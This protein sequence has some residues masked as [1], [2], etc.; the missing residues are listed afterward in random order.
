MGEDRRRSQSQSVNVISIFMAWFMVGYA[1]AINVLMRNMRTKLVIMNGA[2]IM[3]NSQLLVVTSHRT[4]VLTCIEQT[5]IDKVLRCAPCRRLC[6]GRSGGGGREMGNTAAIVAWECSHEAMVRYHRLMYTD[7]KV[8]RGNRLM[9]FAH[10]E[11]TAGPM[12]G[13]VSAVRNGVLRN[14]G[15]KFADAGTAEAGARALREQLAAAAAAL[16]RDGVPV[17]SRAPTAGAVDATRIVSG[18]ALGVVG[19][20][21]V[22][23]DPPSAA[24]A[25]GFGAAGGAPVPTFG[26]GAAVPVAVGVPVSQRTASGGA[27][28]L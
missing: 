7:V 28:L 9:L 3:S 22:A 27:P 23:V 6:G 18:T 16:D 1:M 24:S 17:A 14:M 25:A 8:D 2:S 19:P 13:D 20:S 21:Y 15:V 4:L 10:V 26:A 11:G 5:I 12:A